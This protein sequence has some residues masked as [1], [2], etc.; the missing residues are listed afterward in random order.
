MALS[1]HDDDEEYAEAKGERRDERD[2]D[3]HKDP[4]SA[5]KMA[6]KQADNG[7]R[8]KVIDDRTVSDDDR[9]AETRE[10]DLL[11]Y[12]GLFDEN[13][14]AAIED[15]GKKG[16]MPRYRTRDRSDRLQSHPC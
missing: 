16:P 5:G 6:E 4:R 14:H 1:C 7:D 15:F 3:G 8:Q 2:T 9:Q 11:Q 13:C 10:G 12:R